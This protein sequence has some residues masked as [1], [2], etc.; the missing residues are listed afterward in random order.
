MTSLIF[1]TTWTSWGLYGHDSCASMLAAF[2]AL[3]GMHNA[4]HKPAHVN[5]FLFHTRI[6]HALCDHRT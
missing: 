5:I 1:C 3:H 6:Y 4:V 2:A